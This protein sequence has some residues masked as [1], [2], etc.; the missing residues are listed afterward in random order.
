MLFY[1]PHDF[2]QPPSSLRIGFLVDDAGQDQLKRK[3]PDRVDDGGHDDTRGQI[4][5]WEDS[6]GGFL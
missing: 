5:G 1:P 2:S 3:V 4:C 6:N